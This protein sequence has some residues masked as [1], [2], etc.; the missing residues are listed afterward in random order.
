MS[1]IRYILLWVPR[2]LC[3]CPISHCGCQGTHE[4][5]GNHTP[6][7]TVH[8]SPCAVHRAPG[9]TCLALSV[10]ARR[11]LTTAATDIHT[12]L[13]QHCT[14]VLHSPQSPY[15]HRQCPEPLPK[16]GR[17][18]ARRPASACSKFL[19]PGCSILGSARS[20][21]LRPSAHTI[22][23]VNERRCILGSARL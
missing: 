10:P 12:G 22:A 15:T 19:S 6:A 2:D 9:N 17:H 5:I 3:G 14:K 16:D 11:Y 18:L 13:N 8:I 7:C 23:S 21:V 4:E 1:K 20:A